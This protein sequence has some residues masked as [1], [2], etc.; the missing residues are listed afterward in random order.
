MKKM[1]AAICMVAAGMVGFINSK[2]SNQSEK[3][4]LLTENVEALTAGDTSGFVGTALTWFLKETKGVIARY[5]TRA[6]VRKAGKEV[7]KDICI[8]VAIGT[9]ESSFEAIYNSQY[10]YEPIVSSSQGTN[11]DPYQTRNMQYLPNGK[12]KEQLEEESHGVYANVKYTQ[13]ECQLT[14][15]QTSNC[16]LLG[17]T[18]W[19]EDAH[20]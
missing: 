12:H 7:V 3:S 9:A 14:D 8:D 15:A 17:V 19:Q 11:Q 5:C 18:Y 6:T 1:L 4:M 2:A 16:Y 13:M 20:I 10:P